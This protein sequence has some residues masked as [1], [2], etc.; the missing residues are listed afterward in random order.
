MVRLS[1][2][3]FASLLSLVALAADAPAEPSR[4]WI[5]QS[6]AYTNRLLAVQL[7]HHPERGSRE[8]V[9]KYDERVSNPTLEDEMS[10]RHELEGELELLHDHVAEELACGLIEID[11][12]RLV[13]RPDVEYLADLLLI[14]GEDEDLGG[15]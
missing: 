10:E 11:R 12:G 2:A 7:E 8:G 3:I 4:A 6:N 5:T 1:V 15:S 14:S 9:A 13:A